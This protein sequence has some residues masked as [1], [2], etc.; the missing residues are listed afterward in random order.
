MH[1]DLNEWYINSGI[2]IPEGKLESRWNAVEEF[3]ES[4]SKS[5]INSLTLY[6]LGLSEDAEII[7]KLTAILK[8]HDDNFSNTHVRELRVLSG[9]V[10]HQIVH[11]DST[12]SAYTELLLQGAK[13]NRS[14]SSLILQEIETEY[15]NESSSLRELAT[16][17]PLQV[18]IPSSKKILTEKENPQWSTE[19]ITIFKSFLN[20]LEKSLLN[21]QAFANGVNNIQSLRAEESQLLWW[22]TNSWS[23]LADCPYKSLEQSKSCM[24]IAYDICKLVENFPGPYSIKPLI[25]K[26]L[27]ACKKT[28][29]KVTFAEI[30]QETDSTMR[31][32]IEQYSKVEDI[33]LF[34][35]IMAILHSK[36]TSTSE[37][38]KNKYKIE[39]NT[40]DLVDK[41]VTPL[42]ISLQLYYELLA[43]KCFDTI[44]S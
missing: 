16:I 3:P 9:A 15:F 44:P 41:Q 30:I 20:E 43:L 26:M 13:F 38:W 6:F 2:T 28:K 10:L 31:N 42:E 35:V 8:A 39:S 29:S 27:E 24:H 7:E 14:I 33:K 18:A 22:L 25:T 4:V 32:H 12:Y 34:P 19:S 23:D 5:D 21:V 1:N 36:N 37:E 17:K 40:S 11:H